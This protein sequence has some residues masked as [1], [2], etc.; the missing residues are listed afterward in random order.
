MLCIPRYKT[1]RSGKP[2]IL[3]RPVR[4]LYLMSNRIPSSTCAARCLYQDSITYLG[5]GSH[6]PPRL[7]VRQTAARTRQN[8][9]VS[10]FL[11]NSIFL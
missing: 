1:G 11:Y 5:R 9:D 6:D 8:L 7:F 10:M 4:P 3:R 2:G